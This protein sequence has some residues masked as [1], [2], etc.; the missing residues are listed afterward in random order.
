MNLITNI[1]GKEILGR[2]SAKCF[3][4]YLRIVDLRENFTFSLFSKSPILNVYY[5][6]CHSKVAF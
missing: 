6:Y 2:K 5:F 3:C 4:G 1:H